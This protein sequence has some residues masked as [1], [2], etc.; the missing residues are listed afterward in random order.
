MS[1]SNELES[2]LAGII[3]Y[4]KQFRFRYFTVTA[5]SNTYDD[6]VTIAKSGND[7]WVSGL[8]F[9]VKGEGGSNDAQLLSQGLIQLNDQKLYVN[10]SIDTSG[11]FLVG[12][13]SP[14]TQ[15][16]ALTSGGVQALELEDNKVYKK[17]F[18]RHLTAG[19]LYLG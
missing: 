4:G 8:N 7:V 11:T 9:P 16:M 15:E 13:G 19:S 2:E 18:L 6:D 5:G 3:Q 10:G 14:A 17:L 12:V 1:L